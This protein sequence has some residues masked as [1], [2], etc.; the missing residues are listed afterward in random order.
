MLITN[1]CF[2][3]YIYRFK[4]TLTSHCWGISGRGIWGG[5]GKLL[6]T[7][8][9]CTCSFISKPVEE[10]QTS[11]NTLVDAN[12]TFFPHVDT[13]S[14]CHTKIWHTGLLTAYL[15]SAVTEAGLE[16]CWEF[17]NLIK[18]NK[19]ILTLY[20]NDIYAIWINKYQTQKKFT[21]NHC[22]LPIHLELKDLNS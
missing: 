13:M 6:A 3:I 2:L 8:C 7:S 9:F 18:Q 5:A 10:Q 14:D 12:G 22:E 15:P 4:L 16:E 17:R 21:G 20:D 11:L 1:I 19:H